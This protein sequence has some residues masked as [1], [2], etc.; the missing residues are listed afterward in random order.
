MSESAAATRALTF[1]ERLTAVQK[2]TNSL[3]CV[4]IDPLPDR[5]PGGPGALGD[6][7]RNVI[8]A[9]A[10]QVCAYKPQIAHFSALG[11]ERELEALIRQIRDQAPGIPIILDAKRTD[12]GSTAERYAVE[13]F[14]RYGADAVTVSP[15]TGPEGLAPFLNWHDRGVIIL[16]RTSNAES[17]WLQCYPAEDPLYLRIARRAQEE[18]NTH[19]NVMLVAGATH[20]A[21]LGRIRQVAP[22]LALLVPGIGE[23]AG[24]VAAV[25]RHGCRND[26][27]GMV[28]N[29]SRS[30]IYAGDGSPGAVRNAA[31]DFNQRM[32]EL[33]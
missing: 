23:Q 22:D 10:D 17:D 5:I 19:G 26:G 14:E 6:F 25:L 11:A 16:C 18:W 8:E 29:S 3:L 1:N 28:I 9:T 2:A 33:R 32:R 30:I 31:L 13:A 7:C 27:Y 24:D 21:D 12:I 20:P 15:Y 4:G